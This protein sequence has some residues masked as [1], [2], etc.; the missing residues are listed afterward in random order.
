MSL[1]SSKKQNK[2]K[3]KKEKNKKEKKK[4]EALF[5]RFDR[6]VT[7]GYDFDCS[8]EYEL[9]IEAGAAAKQS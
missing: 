2:K 3:N 6:R 8:K 5:G 1:T 7:V 4:E 9:S